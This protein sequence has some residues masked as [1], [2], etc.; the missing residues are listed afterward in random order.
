MRI[1][2]AYKATITVDGRQ[3]GAD[4]ELFRD[5]KTL[6]SLYARTPVPIPAGLKREADVEVMVTFEP[7]VVPAVRAAWFVTTKHEE[8]PD[9]WEETGD[10]GPFASQDEADDWIDRVKGTLTDSVFFVREARP[11]ES[12]ELLASSSTMSSSP[13]RRPR[14]RRGR[15]PQRRPP[16]RATRPSPWS[17]TPP[18][19]CA[20]PEVIMRESTA[21]PGG[22][23]VVIRDGER[24]STYA[25]VAWSRRARATRCTRSSASSGTRCAADEEA[26][27]A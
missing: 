13:T 6:R 26:P 27:D 2:G 23:V 15:R 24:E 16:M 20:M 10:F 22:V 21:R 18:S 11:P 5:G 1:D 4:A 8:G 9:D 19:R 17:T 12:V 14:R 7:P 25:R 3:V